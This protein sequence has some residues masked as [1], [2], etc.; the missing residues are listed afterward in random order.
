MSVIWSVAAEL[1]QKKK[2][3]FAA[4]AILAVFSVR[5]ITIVCFL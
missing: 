4:N 2:N 3:V 5:D 1:L